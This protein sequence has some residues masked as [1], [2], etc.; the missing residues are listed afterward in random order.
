MGSDLQLFEEDYFPHQWKF[1]TSENPINGLIAGFGSGENLKVLLT[2]VGQAIGGFIGGIGAGIFKQLE[3]INTEKLGALGTGIKDIGLGMMAFAGGQAAGVV[4]GVMESV[5]GFFGAD[6][7]LEKVAELSK[8]KDI[9]VARLQELG[10]G[11]RS[12]AECMSS[13]AAVDSTAMAANAMSLAVAMQASKG[14]ETGMLDK[15]GGFFTSLV[16]G[17]TKKA[18]TGGLITPRSA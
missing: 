17:G 5:A 10:L 14:E 12:L 1:L 16:G 2:N 9:N 11:I 18:A 6:S 3:T 15:V 7:P 13:F 8:D 4:G